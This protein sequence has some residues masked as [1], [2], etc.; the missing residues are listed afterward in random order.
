MAPP[1]LAGFKHLNLCRRLVLLL[2]TVLLLPP[3]ALGGDHAQECTTY[4]VPRTCLR[5][6]WNE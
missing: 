1:F 6:D 5:R 4:K 2:C 3:S